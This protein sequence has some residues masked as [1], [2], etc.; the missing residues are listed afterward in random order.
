MKTKLKLTRLQAEHLKVL[1]L[2]ETT[3]IATDADAGDLPVM[4]L[5]FH[6]LD[7]IKVLDQRLADRLKHTLSVTLPAA[8]AVALLILL[9]HSFNRHDPAS[10]RSCELS[11]IWE[12]LL[13]EY[14]Y[15]TFS[16]LNPCKTS[17][18]TSLLNSAEP[19]S[20]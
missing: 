14:N 11:P 15:L 18:K 3:T 13:Q 1:C 10:E 17:L 2:D 19:Y 8:P 5:Q 16:I 12:Q 7:L 9:N 20:R 6:A 4:L